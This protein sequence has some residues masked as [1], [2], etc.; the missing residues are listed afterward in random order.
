[1]QTGSGSGS[2]LTRE[3]FKWSKLMGCD[4]LKRIGCGLYARK[5]CLAL[6]LFS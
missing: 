2:D 3:L 4:G 5:M 6:P 1:M